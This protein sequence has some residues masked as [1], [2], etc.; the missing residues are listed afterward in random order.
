MEYQAP[1]PNVGLTVLVTVILTALIVGG[2][3]WYWQQKNASPTPTASP[4]SYASPSTQSTT[5]ATPTTSATGTSFTSSK[6]GYSLTLPAGYTISVAQ[7]GE[8]GYMETVQVLKADSTHGTNVVMP[9]G[10]TLIATANEGKQTMDQFK[11]SVLGNVANVSEQSA[12]PIAGEKVIKENIGG[13][14]ETDE[15][16]FQ[17]NGYNFELKTDRGGTPLDPDLKLVM[18]NL[19]FTQ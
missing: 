15:Y 3:M 4:I 18:Q 9:T 19:K 16:L 2:G 6:L 10:T 12:D 17:H 1:R 5:S 14:G 13:L 8:G 7:G 11:K